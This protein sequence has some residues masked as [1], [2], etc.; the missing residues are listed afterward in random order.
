VHRIGPDRHGYFQGGYSQAYLFDDGSS[1][2]L[3]TGRYE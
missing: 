3:G 2:V 1:L